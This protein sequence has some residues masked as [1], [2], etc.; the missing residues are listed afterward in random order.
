MELRCDTCH[1]SPT[2]QCRI[3]KKKIRKVQS[4]RWKKYVFYFGKC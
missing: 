2:F 1:Y 3:I 4:V